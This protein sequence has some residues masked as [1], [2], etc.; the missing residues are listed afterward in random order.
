MKQP[1]QGKD[2][3]EAKVYSFEEML[4]EKGFLAYT[5]VGVSM[6][7][8]LRQRRDIIE[9]HKKVPN[10]RC[11]KYD[12]V[13]Y[14]T[15]EKYILHRVIKVR[16]NDYGADPRC[17]DPGDTK[18]EVYLSDRVEVQVIRTFVVRFIPDSG[19]DFVY[20]QAGSGSQAKGETVA[21]ARG[22]RRMMMAKRI[23]G[24]QR[25]HRKPIIFY[26]I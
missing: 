21:E 23:S 24:K 16:D 8:F 20:D 3:L 17:D 22:K 18:R 26:N 19:G 7:P 15:G 9:I 10:V 12:V 4:D 2:M 5:N 25:G 6:M 11:K 1:V 13:L 14:K